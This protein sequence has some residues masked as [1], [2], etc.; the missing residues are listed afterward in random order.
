MCVCV[1]RRRAI[2]SRHKVRSH[3]TKAWRHQH[4]QNSTSLLVSLSR[5]PGTAA[6]ELGIYA[7]GQDTTIFTS[8]YMI[9]EPDRLFYMAR[10][11]SDTSRWWY[12]DI[13]GQ[14]L[15]PTQDYSP[16]SYSVSAMVST[17][18]C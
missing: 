14:I 5:A 7:V 6:A 8:S 13:S 10:M 11:A 18:R 9:F 16:P 4:L 12:L 2:L 17:V 3:V 15:M 1:R